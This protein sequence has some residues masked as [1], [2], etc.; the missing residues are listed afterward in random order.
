MIES[1]RSDFIRFGGMELM[2]KIIIGLAIFILGIKIIKDI[3]NMETLSNYKFRKREIINKVINYIIFLID[4]VIIIL[5]IFNI[6]LL[7]IN[8]FLIF[9]IAIIYLVLRIWYK[10]SLN[11]KKEIIEIY[12]DGKLMEM[13][14]VKEG[15]A[16][17]KKPLP[18][19]EYIIKE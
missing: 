14:E 17:L 10:V 16:K 2:G 4:I 5:G 3:Y 1:I 6:K 8:I 11:D 12:K 19:G 15:V 18:I 9:T 13:A 7:N